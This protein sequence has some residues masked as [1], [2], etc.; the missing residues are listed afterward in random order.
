MSGGVSASPGLRPPGIDA[1]RRVVSVL[2][3]DDDAAVRGVVAKILSNRGC[4][5][6][7]AGTGAEAL[8]LLQREPSDVAFIDVHMPVMNGLDLA[9]QLRREHP[10]TAI[11]MLTGMAEFGTVLAAIQAGAAD[12]V[13][14]PFKSGEL[15][16]AYER[17]VERRTTIVKAKRTAELE[18]E[19][20]RQSSEL[21]T[22][23]ANSAS[24]ASGLVEAFLLALRARSDAQA[25]HAYRVAELGVR[26]GQ[27]LELPAPELE[28]LRRAALLH[29]IGQLAIPDAALG[30]AAGDGDGTAV[31][32]RYPQIGHDIVSRVP[33]LADCA[34]GILAH[35]EHMDGSGFPLG[36]QGT[37]IPLAARIIAVADAH[38]TLTHP[39]PPEKPLPSAAAIAQIE[40]GVNVRFDPTVVTALLLAMGDPSEAS[41][42]A[43]VSP[44]EQG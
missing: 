20:A 24:T 40:Q 30:G 43:G 34:R 44:A 27:S 6:R 15:I 8:Q 36:L 17:A 31:I 25:A 29:E 10:D 4:A 21:A 9:D 37:A 13:A 38:D 19:V 1:G 16:K 23:L 28:V 5:F 33:A 3:V 42:R 11:V 14:K 41:F 22:S 35:R 2:I 7:M 12:F 32:R 18:R 26:I 39:V